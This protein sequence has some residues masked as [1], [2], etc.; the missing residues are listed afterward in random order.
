MRSKT[1]TLALVTTLTFAATAT[2]CHAQSAA[3]T[4]FA[5]DCKRCHDVSDFEGQSAAEIAQELTAIVQGKAKHRRSLKM[6]PDEINL[7][8]QYLA[9]H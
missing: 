1:T 4:A 2:V 8:S 7:M 5:K 3:S 9:G 6:T